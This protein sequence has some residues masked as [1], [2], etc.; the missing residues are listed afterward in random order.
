[1][2]CGWFHLVYYVKLQVTCYLHHIVARMEFQKGLAT[3]LSSCM[4][5]QGK[6]LFILINNGLYR[7]KIFKQWSLY[8]LSSWVA[9]WR[10]WWPSTEA[11]GGDLD[12][13]SVKETSSIMSFILVNTCQLAWT[14][15]THACWSLLIHVNPRHTCMNRLPSTLMFAIRCCEHFCLINALWYTSSK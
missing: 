10:R 9:E 2:H 15:L 4:P 8:W 3:A 12:R 7:T 5:S 6:A 14:I 1:M 11:W 13:A